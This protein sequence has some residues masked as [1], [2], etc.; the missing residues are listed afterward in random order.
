VKPRS[1]KVAVFLGAAALAG[2]AGIGVAAGAKGDGTASTSTSMSGQRPPGQGAN[3]PDFSALAKK[4]GVSE[5]KLQAAMQS[6]RP[7]Q[8]AQPGADDMAAKLAATLGL[9]ESKVQSALDLVR[10]S[11]APGGGGTPPQGGSAP[12]SS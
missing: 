1:R 5:S 10:P 8:G 12:S 3:A 6:I 4:L 11:G 9:S 2:G 7:G